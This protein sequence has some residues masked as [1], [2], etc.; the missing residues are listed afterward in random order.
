MARRLPR[1]FYARDVRVVAPELLGKVVRVGAVA[2]RIVEV[3]AYAGA[4][5]P[6]SHAYRGETA[7]NRTMF[8]PAGHLYVYFTYGMHFCANAVC[9]RPGEAGAVL[10]RALTPM[11]GLSEMRSRRPVARRDR[12]LCRGPARL[13]QA[14]GID[15]DLDG[16]DLTAAGSQVV[17]VDDGT[18][19]PARP[20][21]SACVGISVAT[22]RRWR[23]FVPGD[24]HLSRVEAALVCEGTSRSVPREAVRKC[25]R[26]SWLALFGSRAIRSCCVGRTGSGLHGGGR[27]VTSQVVKIWV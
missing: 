7:R 18:P 5:D 12:D 22:E 16:A 4:E 2:G 23:W 1:S 24:P 25:P 26:L 13:C 9:G 11:E 10:V 15:R 27:A 3:E 8:G 17:F 21:R 20:G 19:P 6:A 14:L